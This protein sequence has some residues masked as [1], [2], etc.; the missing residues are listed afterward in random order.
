MGNAPRPRFMPHRR[1]RLGR[2]TS[3]R[4]RRFPPGAWQK[5]PIHH[6]E[7]KSKRLN[8]SFG[9]DDRVA[10]GLATRSLGEGSSTEGERFHAGHS[11]SSAARVGR[12]VVCRSR[13]PSRRAWAVEAL[14][15]RTL[16]STWP[17]TSLADSGEHT[18]RWAIDQANAN[19]GDDTIDIQV[20]GT[21]ELKS[22][23]ADLG[24]TTGLTDI[25][26][27][28]AD[29]LSVA[30]SDAAGIPKFRI[31]TVDAGATVKLVGITITGGQA[32]NSDGGGIQNSGTLAI[33]LVTL[34]GNELPASMDGWR[35]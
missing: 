3:K 5:A 33:D 20:T 35:Y 19:T 12:H 17:V 4:P 6:E 32:D 9:R 1:A 27:P 15:E 7:S 18:L 28:G 30:R 2:P 8:P 26:G 13:R 14:E 11:S 31:F 25:E 10:P 23:L 22:A 21:I 24:D 34:A 29:L 16:L